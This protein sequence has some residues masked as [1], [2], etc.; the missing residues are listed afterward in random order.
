MKE[1]KE[2]KKKS[3]ILRII[4]LILIILLFIFVTAA[5]TAFWYVSN[6]LGKINYMDIDEEN[7]EISSEAKES[8]SGYRNIALFGIDTRSDSY[9]TSRSDCIIIV[10]I[11]EKTKEVKL[12]SVYRDS[13][14]DITGRGLDKVTHA[15]A[16][17]GPEKS[18]STLNRNLDLNIK[19][20]VTVNFEAA[21]KIVDAVDGIKMTITDVEATQISGISKGGTYTLTG[22][23]A[24]EYARIRHTDSDYKRTERMRDVLTAVFNKV[25]TMSIG[26]INKLADEILPLVYT[27]IKSDEIFDLIPDAVSYKISESVGWPYEI[28]GATINKIWYGVP[29][30]L[31]ENVRKMHKEMFNEDSYEPSETVKNI[32]ESI[33]KKTGYR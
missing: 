6:K 12:M 9:A 30:N 13:Y 11:N 28:K 16:Y 10:S 19:E 18:I 31:E 7:L 32:S 27:N 14:L 26:R 22:S 8:L 17:G 24:L 5:G 15:Y 3:K 29:V 20:F 25:K 23:Q 1:K 4:L 21:K 33:K 2:K